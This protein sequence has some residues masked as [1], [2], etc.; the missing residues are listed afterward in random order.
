MENGE[1]ESHLSYITGSLNKERVKTTQP[2]DKRAFEADMSERCTGSYMKLSH[3]VSGCVCHCYGP[4]M[5][6]ILHMH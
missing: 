1:R 2:Y 6:E 4:I 5:E 3:S